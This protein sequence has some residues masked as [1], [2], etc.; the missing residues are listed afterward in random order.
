M[1]P[2][3]V[4]KKLAGKASEA[5]MAI[6]AMDAIVKKFKGGG[7]VPSPGTNSLYVLDLENISFESVF[8]F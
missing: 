7:V 5:E 6:E 1:P 2:K 3:A 8:S 4:P